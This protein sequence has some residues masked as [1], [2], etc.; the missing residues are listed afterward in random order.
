MNHVEQIKQ[1]DQETSD[2]T[3]CLYVMTQNELQVLVMEISKKYF[4]WPFKHIARFNTR[5]KTTGG[6]Y[7]LVSHDLE[8]N[9]KM[10]N[11]PEFE[12]IVKHELVH[13]HLHMQQRGYQ[14]KDLDF[15]KLLAQV[16]GSRFAPSLKQ[17]QTT[18]CFW[19]Y[20]CENGHNMTRKRR[21]QEKNYRCGQCGGKIRFLG[22]TSNK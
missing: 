1:N 11:L 16:G 18:Q 15:K 13:Y 19:L 2:K 17:E 8:F 7:L 5:L 14:H 21:F 9:L 4:G 22:Q 10:A 20:C 3:H 12:G 6:R